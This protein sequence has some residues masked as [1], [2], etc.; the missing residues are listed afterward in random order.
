MVAHA[1]PVDSPARQIAFAV[2]AKIAGEGG[3]HQREIVEALHAALGPLDN[4][5]QTRV[6]AC[7]AHALADQIQPMIEAS[8]GDVQDV[9]LAVDKAVIDAWI[10]R[11]IREAVAAARCP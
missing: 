8:G 9:C 10:S 4:T 7:F 2:S 6:A 5:T 1:Q 3:S 11:A